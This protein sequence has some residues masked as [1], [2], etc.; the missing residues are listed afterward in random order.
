MF[1]SLDETDDHDIPDGHRLVYVAQDPIPWGANEV[2]RIYQEEGWYINWYL[3]CYDNKI[4]EIRF[5]WEP[6]IDDMAIVNQKL[7]H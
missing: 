5:D 7:N 6:D 1:Y 4:L 2:Y 3:I